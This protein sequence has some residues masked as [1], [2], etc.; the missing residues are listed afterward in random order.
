MYQILFHPV[1]R[2]IRVGF[3]ARYFQEGASS[4]YIS[5]TPPMPTLWRDSRL[6]CG[7]VRISLVFVQRFSKPR[8]SSWVGFMNRSK[9]SWSC[10][11][12]SGGFQI[13]RVGSGV[14]P[15]KVNRTVKGSCLLFF[16]RIPPLRSETTNYDHLPGP[17]RFWSKGIR[18]WEYE[19]T[20]TAFYL[21]ARFTVVLTSPLVAI[22]RGACFLFLS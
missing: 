6:T 7:N 3:S 16:C 22:F 5:S 11:V 2:S 8:G 15:R 18:S 19:H 1:G 17:P 12:E 10:R 14:S 21:E 4:T 20:G 13:S 9:P